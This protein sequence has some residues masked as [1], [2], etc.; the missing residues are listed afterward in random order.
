MNEYLF[1]TIQK[2]KK[3]GLLVDTNILLLYIVGSLDI[4]LIRNFGRTATFTTDDFSVISEFIEFFEV[5]ITTPHILTE[6]SNLIGNRKNLQTVLKKYIELTQEKFTPSV[7]V[8]QN[9]SFNIFGLADTAIADTARDFFL[10]VTDDKPL[11]G[12]LINRGID[13]VS[14]DQ[15]RI[16]Q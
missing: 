15:L 9:D 13:A 8:T 12:Y 10:V 11:F 16:N 4:E 3:R 14:L 7:E 1:E 6:V 5:K 2:Y